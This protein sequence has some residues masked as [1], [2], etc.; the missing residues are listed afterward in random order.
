MYRHLVPVAALTA[1]LA[2][3]APAGAALR[4]PATATPIQHVVVI[5]LENHSFD[6]LLGFWCQ[7][8]PARCLDA[9]GNFTGMPAAVALSDGTVVTPTVDPGTVPNVNHDGAAQV[10][11]MNGGAM[12]GW[13]NI[14][15][16]GKMGGCGAAYNY[17]CVS[18][19]QPSQVPNI[20]ALASRFAISDA[21]FSLSDSPSW[22]G[23]LYAVAASAD[24]FWG[25][26]PWC[27]KGGTCTT[28]WG[29]DSGQ[30]VTWWQ[31]SPTAKL[32]KA[33]PCVPDYSLDPAQFPYGGAWRAAPAP[34]IPTI[35]DRLDAAGLPW[36]I[37]GATTATGNTQGYGAWDICPSF[38]ECRYGPQ[39]ANLVP[40]AQFA[41]DAAAGNLPAFSVVTP[42]G[43]DFKNSCHN[44]ESITACDNWLGQLVSETGASPDWP[45]TVVFITWDDFGG[46]YDGSYP[47]TLANPDG[48]QEGPRVPLIIVS[49]YARPGFTDTTPGTFAGILAFTEQNFGLP[50]LGVNDAA[51]Y[52]FTNA[53]NYAQAPL[54]PARMVT[55][56][57][58][59]KRIRQTPAMLREAS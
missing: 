6:S 25:A 18:G 2:A 1:A 26:N 54:R 32:V 16:K 11:A 12:N 43:P 10:A 19:Y 30:K 45:S 57:L 35:M 52:P 42:G 21:T 39:D 50:P 5:Y 4:A 55:R 17:Q 51:A 7:Q 29:C 31:S 3:A 48:T 8:N 28:G 38:A 59:A 27:V 20:T 34:Y 15:P 37:Y 22:E 36:K 53:F 44:G 14:P 9:A 56:P 23:H 49:P 33:P 58:P 13:E 41:T 47:G 24:G 46:F 40:D